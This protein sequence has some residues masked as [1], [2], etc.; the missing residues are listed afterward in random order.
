MDVNEGS[1]AAAAREAATTE[2]DRRGFHRR[3]YD[4][5]LSWSAHPR[6][7]PALAVLSFAEASFFL[8]P[9]DVLLIAMTVAKP[10]RARWYAFVCTVSSVAGGLAGYGIG[11]AAWSALEDF[12]FRRLGLLGLTPENFAMVQE[13]YDAN[14]F[15]ALFS[16]GFTPIPFKVF[17]IAAGVF[18]VALPVFLLAATLGRA[19]RFFLVAEL[20]ARFG[21]KVQPF[22]EKYLG[23][24][25]ILF[26]ALLAAGFFLLKHL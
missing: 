6:A 4:W 22:I 7:V 3:M 1:G 10:A 17:T 26:V 5:V 23:W 13:K 16:A 11:W 15:L 14:A 8:I 12:A 20:V 9:P 21:P 24:L 19:G 2:P 25:T 18:G